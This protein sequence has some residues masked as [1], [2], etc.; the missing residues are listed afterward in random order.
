MPKGYLFILLTL[1]LALAAPLGQAQEQ[2]VEVQ[3][4]TTEGQ[5]QPQILPLPIPVEI[6]ESDAA[7]DARQ[8]SEN[9]AKEREIRD[10][11]AQEGVN[12]ATQ[13]MNEATQRMA[14]YAF[15]STVIVGVGTVLLFWTLYET[16]QANKAA[17]SSI[18]AV[19]DATFHEL[20]PWI[21]PQK[22]EI[23][24]RNDFRLNESGEIIDVA[25]VF[26]IGWLNGGATPAIDVEVY[27][28][29]QTVQ[30]G[31]DPPIFGEDY[32]YSSKFYLAAN[33]IANSGDAV[34]HGPDIEHFLSGEKDAYVHSRI[35]YKSVH[36]PDDLLWSEAT[37]RIYQDGEFRPTGG[38]KRPNIAW[39]MK[40][41]Q[42]VK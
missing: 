1:G 26:S 15:W 39:Q 37:F 24:K 6:V 20:R 29:I 22:P 12:A 4:T 25:Y 35:Q 33:G 36:R 30:R 31:S 9:E 17:A 23:E 11:A 19:Q 13:T 7:S 8:R 28:T 2:D 34:V 18:E 32:V 10:L 41:Q 5:G 40:G 38:A 27:S 14:D 21:M 3:E 42:A 16:R